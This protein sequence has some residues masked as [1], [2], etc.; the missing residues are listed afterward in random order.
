MVTGSWR[1]VAVGV[2]AAVAV[3]LLGGLATD[4]GPWYRQLV[5]PSWQPP[6]W[7]FGPVWT[8]IYAL[9]VIAGVRSWRRTPTTAAREW[10]VVLFAA[11]AFVNVLWSLLFFRLRHPDW[12][13]LDVGVL[14][15]SVLALT[16][17]LWRRDRLG[18]ALMLPYLAWVSF[19]SFLNL[20]I[21]SLNAPFSGSM[22]TTTVLID[23]VLAVLALEAAIL[24]VVSRRHR[25][26]PPFG[27][28]L[29]NLA[30]GFFL[31]V[32]L[33]GVASAGDP[34]ILGLS[35]LAA[36]VAHAVDLAGRLRR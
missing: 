2:L 16:V 20:V 21:V 19:A 25:R 30:A 3:G 33:R 23:V 31:V 1:P 6:D 22:I 35:L 12:A 18:G 13:L 7:L 5:K 26:L 24:L 32:A 34:R 36:G 29:P 28:L 27:K 9:V 15:A 8:T 10:L 17:V 11:N 4:I 14:W